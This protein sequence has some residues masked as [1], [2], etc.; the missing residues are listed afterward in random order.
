MRQMSRKAF[1][2]DFDMHGWSLENFDGDDRL[3]DAITHYPSPLSCGL[4]DSDSLPLL[5]S[6]AISP[7]G[8][9]VTGTY[10]RCND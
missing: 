7:Y 9:R 2:S 8:D 10:T 5:V 6:L 3:W 1:C 4:P